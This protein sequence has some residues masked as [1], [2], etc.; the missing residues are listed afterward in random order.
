M[1]TFN[2][3]SLDGCGK[4]LCQGVFKCVVLKEMTLDVIG[5]K[6]ECTGLSQLSKL[7]YCI[8]AIVFFLN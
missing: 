3:M 2:G 4:T 5:C 1:C 6:K 8:F 7:H